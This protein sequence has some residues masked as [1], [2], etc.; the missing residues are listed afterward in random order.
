MNPEISFEKAES[1]VFQILNE[2]T[3]NIS[4]TELEKVKNK[5]EATLVFGYIDILNKATG[6]AFFE[7]MGD[8]NLIN[9][10]LEEYQRVTVTDLKSALKKYLKIENASILYYKS[11]KN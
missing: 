4:E 8:A 6:L 11:I 2:L 3:E 1:E 7:M 10:E 9:T 5:A